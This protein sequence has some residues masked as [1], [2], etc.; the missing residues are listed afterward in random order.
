MSVSTKTV[1]GLGLIH[2]APSSSVRSSDEH[3]LIHAMPIIY[4][5]SSPFYYFVYELG[6]GRRL[7][8]LSAVN[9]LY[10]EP[11]LLVLLPIPLTSL[12]VNPRVPLFNTS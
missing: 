8:V 6:S 4:Y 12:I 5:V 2:L 3:V 1:H 7:R 11:W 10:C 9:W